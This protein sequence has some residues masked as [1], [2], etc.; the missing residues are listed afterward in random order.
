[1]ILLECWFWRFQDQH[2]MGVRHLRSAGPS[3]SSRERVTE[4]R[5]LVFAEQDHS[6]YA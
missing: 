5:G 6:M 1:M 4:T 3:R 2:E